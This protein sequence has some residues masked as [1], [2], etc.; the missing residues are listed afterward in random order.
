VPSQYTG[1]SIQTQTISELSAIGAPTRE[2]WVALCIPY[3]VLLIAF[4]WGIWLSSRNNWKLRLVGALFIF[5]AIFCGF[6]P[7]MHMRVDLAAGKGSLTDNLHIAW[8]FVHLCLIL[9]AIGFAAI[10]LGRKFRIYSILTV[11]VFLVFGA[12][13]SVEAPGLDKNEPTP[14]IGIWERINIAA[15]MIWISVLALVLLKRKKLT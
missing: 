4:G 8:T 3:T 6:W 10:S 5:D 12:L 9:L 2:I 14:F 15:Y 1:Y 11:I 7:P 13:T